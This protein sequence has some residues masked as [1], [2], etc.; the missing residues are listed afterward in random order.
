MPYRLIDD[1]DGSFRDFFFENIPDKAGLFN[2]AAAPRRA[3]EFDKLSDDADTTITQ[4]HLLDKIAKFFVEHPELD[5]ARALVDMPGLRSIIAT[6]FV[7]QCFKEFQH[8]NALGPVLAAG[9]LNGAENRDKIIGQFDSRTTRK[10][11]SDLTELTRVSNGAMP[12]D[13]LYENFHVGARRLYVAGLMADMMQ[14][15]KTEYTAKQHDT[16]L[17]PE[18]RLDLTRVANHIMREAYSNAPVVY[19]RGEAKL[20]EKAVAQFN[21][22]ATLQGIDQR[23]HWDGEMVSR[24]KPSPP[25]Q[26][27]PPAAN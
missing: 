18:K 3:S 13:V 2:A 19:D 12:E 1:R 20:L 22:L 27:P 21:A 26:L 4:D 23:L 7:G 10:I 14:S 6:G 15:I 8:P 11:A 9:L 16:Q 5:K 24:R 25:K 17:P